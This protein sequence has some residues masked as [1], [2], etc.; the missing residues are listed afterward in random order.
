ARTTSALNHPNILTLYDI[1]TH[2]GK[3]YIVTELLIGEELRAQLNDGP[4][5]S[6]EAVDYAQQIAQG[7]GAAHEK[8][9]IHRD[10]KPENLF[11]TTGGRIK[12]LDFGLAKLRPQHQ[13]A[14]DSEVAT[15][16]Q[17]TDPGTVM[18]TAGYMSPEQVR[19]QAIDHRS[20][21]FSFGSILYEMLTGQRA[22]RRETMAESMT[23]ILKEEPS[24][25][26]ETNAK[27]NPALEK[28]V[29][30]C[31]Q[32]KPEQRFQSAHDLAFALEALS[33]LS[34]SGSKTSFAPASPDQSRTKFL[35][36]ARLAWIITGVLIL[37]VLIALPFALTYVRKDTS[38]TSPI[39][40]YD[41]SAP[42]KSTLGLVRWPAVAISPDGS[43]L[44]FV[45]TVDGTNRLYI[46][47]RDDPEPRLIAGTEGASNPAFSPNGKLLA[48]VADFTLRKCALDGPVTSVVKIGDARG[49]SWLGDDML[50]YAP[51]PAGALFKISVTGANPQAISRLDESKKERT[52]RWPQVLPNGKAVLFTVGTIDSPDSYERAN[53][54]AVILATGERR[55]ILQNASMARYVPSGHLVFARAGGLY[56]VR[57]DLQTL[58]TNGT[59]EAVLQG[60]SAD[61]TTGASHFAIADDG[62]LAYVPGAGDTTRRRLFWGDRAGNF[63]PLN[64]APAQYNDVRIS[65]D[66]TQV[67]LLVGSS[68]VGD[69]WVY[70]LTRATSTRLTFDV[71]NA[72]PVWTA[73]GNSVYY[74]QIRT[75][76]DLTTLFRKPADGSREAEKVASL[77]TTAYVKAL[78]PDRSAAIFDYQMNI[79]SGDIVQLALTPDAQMVRLV[80]T[81]FNEYAAALSPDG[82][83]LAY[84]SSEGG[85]PEIFVKDLSGSGARTPI[86]TDG[87]EEPRWSANGRELFYRKSNS[88]MSVSVEPGATLHAGT[89]KELFKG[90]YDLRSNSGVTYDVDPKTNRFLMIR[91]ADD[92]TAPTQIR[93][94]VNWFEELRRA[95]PVN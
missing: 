8:G 52:H 40:R 46:R 72:S 14:V 94:V 78:K 79:N 56:A 87:G 25:L 15:E 17:I 45:A 65:P 44:A 81:P 62:T 64:F 38:G 54:E 67:A 47:K 91:P 90:V 70:D 30:R 7:L 83:W 1:G 95:V 57:F 39:V 82:R 5:S 23:A 10:L 75:T 66:G 69:V 42:G 51:D 58:T 41:V 71:S 92:A 76:G 22:F 59:A 80:N 50:V 24:E 28:I 16:K 9:I 63:Q 89:P 61:E 4:L 29:R 68:G 31:L 60:V 73:D 88:F 84:Q 26:S 85:R 43:T 27:I 36:N 49:I 21:I 12:I 2:E 55:L 33:T 93:V 20:D 3:P 48:F 34:G 86:S 6:R 74:T 13:G 37:A 11:V 77:E 32:K 35:S 19:G 18:G 53:I